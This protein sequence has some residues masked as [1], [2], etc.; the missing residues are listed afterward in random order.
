ARRVAPFT[1]AEVRAVGGG[2][3]VAEAEAR[4]ERQG[5]GL[6]GAELR[7]AAGAEAVVAHAFGVAAGEREVRHD[8]AHGRGQR[9]V[10]PGDADLRPGALLAGLVARARA[11]RVRVVVAVG[12]VETG[13]ARE[14]DAPAGA[15]PVT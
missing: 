8:V 10:A 3:P 13:Q 12:D 6:A 9:D 2:E 11:H 7:R 5:P 15:E 14:P 4:G 1:G